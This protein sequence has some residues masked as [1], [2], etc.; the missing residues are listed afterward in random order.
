M[1]RKKHKH[2]LTRGGAAPNVTDNT[3]ESEGVG[4]VSSLW[5]VWQKVTKK[6]N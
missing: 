3:D 4:Q 1:K 2:M 5:V 6:K